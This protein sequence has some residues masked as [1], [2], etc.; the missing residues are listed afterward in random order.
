VVNALPLPVDGITPAD[1]SLR[2]KAQNPPNFG[3]TLAAPLA[4]LD[5][6][7]CFASS[8]EP[9]LVRLDQRIELRFAA[10]LPAGR[11][12]INCTLRAEGGRWRWFGAQFVVAKQAAP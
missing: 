5:G 12:R 10:A 4:G 8:G 9:S 1:M 11:Q 3:F 7:S 2:T 6:L